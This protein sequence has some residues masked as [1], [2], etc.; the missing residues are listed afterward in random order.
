MKILRNKRGAAL[1]SAILFMVV[2][3]MLGML[4]TGVIMSTHLRVKLNDTLLTREI[5]IEQ[6][7]E[8][9]VTMSETDFKKSEMNNYA[10]TTTYET[11][12]KTLS[13]ATQGGKVVL[14][15]EVTT[16]DNSNSVTCWR[17]SAPTPSE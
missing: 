2:V 1:E 3:L 14:Y 11:D 15:I 4:L 16:A 8:N 6:I 9:F 10:P 5:T 7:G 17:Y 12:K 13:L